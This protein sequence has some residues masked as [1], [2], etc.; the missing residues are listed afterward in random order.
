[1]DKLGSQQVFF[2]WERRP[3]W[4]LGR[5]GLHVRLFVL[6]GLAFAA[7]LWLRG[8]E[9]H[10]SAV[11]ATRAAITSAHNATTS[12]RADHQGQ[13][14]HG[15][16]DLVAGGYARDLP[17]DAWGHALR[18]ECTPAGGD[19]IEVAISSDG[20]DGLPQGLDRIR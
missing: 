7:L 3:L 2:P 10:K 6:A 19:G 11:R 12:F 16:A 17:V 14:P 13:C 15:A 4:L 9:E 20:P 18:I 5:R 1:M 8:R